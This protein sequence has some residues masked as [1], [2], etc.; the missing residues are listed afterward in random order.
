MRGLPYF[1][2]FGGGKRVT[3]EEG[4][5]ALTALWHVSLALSEYVGGVITR[6]QWR[7]RGSPRQGNW[8][9]GDP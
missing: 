2:S 5:D 6:L 3:G 8:F 4:G 1:L 9:I 7:G